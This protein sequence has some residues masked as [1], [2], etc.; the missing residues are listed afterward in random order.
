M[1]KPFEAFETELSWQQL[2]LLA[3]TASYFEDA[4]KL[5]S[6]PAASGETVSV[7]LTAE[8]LRTMVE[9]LSEDTPFDK[10]R[11]AISW[12]ESGAD[13]GTVAITMPS[14]EVLEQPTEL[15]HFSLL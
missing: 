15:A 5:L 2:S 14:G 13:N 8:S 3:D 12:K 9:Q 4:P 6:L 11:F 1:E 7:P 10:K